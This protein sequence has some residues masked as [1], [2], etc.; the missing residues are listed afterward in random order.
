MVNNY[1]GMQMIEINGRIARS[2]LTVALALVFQAPALASPSVYPT[3]VTRYDPVKAYNAYVLFSGADDI[4]HLIDMNGH[5]VHRWPH[6]GFPSAVL[7][8]AVTDGERG[9]VLLE[10]EKKAPPPGFPGLGSG[11]SNQSIG[12]VDWNDQVVWQWG[13]EAPG[14]SAQQHHDMRRAANGD[15]YVLADE[16]H[17]VKG[18]VL[19]KI[20]DD[21][22]Y[23]VGK[24]GNVEW[25]WKASDH[26]DEFG[27]TPEQLKL[28]HD[29]RNP[30]VLHVNNM[31]VIGPNRWFDAGDKRFTP[32]NLLIDSRNANFIVIIDRETG[33]VVWRLGPNLPV[34]S[35]ETANRVPR[36]LDQFSGQHD[37]H[38]I[39]EGLPGAGDLIVFD[40]QG[41]AGY[42]A[43]PRDVFSG[44]RVLEIDP[45][46]G[47]IVWQYTG[48]SSGQPPWGFYSS[49]ISSARRLPNGNTLIDEGMTG[50]IFQVTRS[51]EIV[52]EYVSPYADKA[53]KGGGLPALGVEKANGGRPALGNYVYRAQP[54]PY[55]WVPADTPHTEAEVS[56]PDLASFHVGPN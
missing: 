1:L 52:W 35:P 29:T 8:P 22:I 40:N 39:P 54:V 33:K 53:N 43:L 45:V 3:G 16:I 31:S 55:D 34:I 14:G 49:F 26:L 50:R 10:L 21:V 46:K 4:T 23:Q 18:F 5:E 37:A 47:E 11:L 25:T 32:G 56:A 41:E 19:P 15:T 12:E 2:T 44:S 17:A 28:V 27:F 30:D 20:I 38:L 24:A 13:K 42:P 51:G 6:A 7:D 48:A 36:P 9:H